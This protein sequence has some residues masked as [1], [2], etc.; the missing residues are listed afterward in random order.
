MPSPKGSIA[1]LRP[2]LGYAMQEIDLA[3]NAAKMVALR[4]APVLEAQEKAG[5]WGTL[6]AEELLASA[7]DTRAAGQRY[8]TVDFAAPET[9]TFNCTDHGIEGAVDDDEA[10][11]FSEYFDSEMIVAARNRNI[12]LANMESEVAT[13]VAATA[14]TATVSDWT[15]VSSGTPITDVTTQKNTFFTTA[16]RMPNALV[17]NE[18]DFNLLCNCA[19]IIDRIKYSGLQDPNLKNITPQAVAQALNIEEI[20]I[21]GAVYNSANPGAATAAGAATIATIWPT[22]YASLVYVART[23]DPR[24][25]G[26][27]RTIH[28]GQDGSTIGAGI[29]SYR[30]ESRRSNMVRCRMNR[31]VKV[32]YSAAI[33]RLKLG[34]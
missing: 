17:I 3:A 20:I 19:Q 12:I 27:A 13:L 25:P 2:D 33:R 16:G 7:S 6:A 4:V 1:T 21:A 31:H 23:Q 26:W 5:N 8:N 22:G 10:T 18:L 11:Q 14:N 15:N 29:E 24:E 30:D 34:A 9:D 32:R 28:W